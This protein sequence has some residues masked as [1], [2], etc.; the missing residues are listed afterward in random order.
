MTVV[1][2]GTTPISE[3]IQTQ[4]GRG[5]EKLDQAEDVPVHCKGFGLN[6]L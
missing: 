4:V 5:S 1:K 3:H 6:D 2:R